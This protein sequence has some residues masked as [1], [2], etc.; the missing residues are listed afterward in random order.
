MG[1]TRSNSINSFYLTNYVLTDLTL[2][3]KY[4]KLDLQRNLI[5]LIQ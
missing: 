2:S 3:M 4:V 5:N 1:E